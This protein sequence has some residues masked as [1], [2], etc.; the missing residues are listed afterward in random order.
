MQDQNKLPY[1]NF[2]LGFSLGAITLGIAGYL[3]GTK[4]GRTLLKKLLE[5]SENL[6]ENI[7][8]LGEELEE[9]FVEKSQLGQ[10]QK[11][12]QETHSTLHDVLEKIKVRHKI[13]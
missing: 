4:N 10:P 8:L 3:L 12:S 9:N 6:E 7:L 5:L 13:I 11:P 1:S 2:W